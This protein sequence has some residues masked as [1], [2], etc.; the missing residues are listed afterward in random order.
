M[1]H[2]KKNSRAKKY[3]WKLLILLAVIGF[4]LG[5][6]ASIAYNAALHLSLSSPEWGC[7][8]SAIYAIVFAISAI[9]RKF[10]R[11]GLL[12][13]AVFFFIALVPYGL[14]DSGPSSTAAY[15][16][17]FETSMFSLIMPITLPLGL[18]FARPRLRALV[19]PE[20]FCSL[21]AGWAGFSFAFYHAAAHNNACLHLSLTAWQWGLIVGPCFFVGSLVALVSCIRSSVLCGL[22]AGLLV[23]V[24][25]SIFSNGY[26]GLS[27]G[28][29]FG[30]IVGALLGRMID[31]ME[32]LQDL[33][34][35]NK[36]VDSRP[37]EQELVA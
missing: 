19:S 24:V 15:R 33:Q 31:K 13:G 21:L 26:V 17:W 8:W 7:V 6:E 23:M 32:D 22:M 34:K 35:A 11:K 27:F 16:A 10:Y 5:M 4:G 9:N 25:C 12:C 30:A 2:K 1:S 29:P 14:L 36:S 3:P 20:V 28:F 18:L 37:G